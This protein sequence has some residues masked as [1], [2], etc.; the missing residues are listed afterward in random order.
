MNHTKKTLET[1]TESYLKSKKFIWKDTTK[2][3]Q[4]YCSFWIINAFSEL[5]ISNINAIFDEDF[6]NNFVEYAKEK[7]LKN[8]TI[9]KRLMLL[10]VII[11]YAIDNDLVALHKRFTYKKLKDEP[12]KGH[13]IQNIDIPKIIAKIP[14]IF[15]DEFHQVRNRFIILTMLETGA[16][17]SEIVKIQKKNIDL[18]TQQLFLEETKNSKGR[19]INLSSEYIKEFKTFLHFMKN[20]KKDI[21]YLFFSEKGTPCTVCTIRY[22]LLKIE[23][24]M[25]FDYSITSH[26]F[27]RT[28]ASLL[29]QECGDFY[30]VSRQL[31][32]QNIETT[33]QYIIYDN[34]HEREMKERATPLKFIKKKD[35]K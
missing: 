24:K 19:V 14:L 9:N 22:I 29:L 23:A 28:N 18:Q 7:G 10:K 25:D 1:I 32:H 11:N 20:H 8:K 33:K 6:F 15:A 13:K 12:F 31:G 3:I 21:D 4:R 35:R 27:R 17:R 5:K 30:Y 34:D 16:R 26:V 2:N